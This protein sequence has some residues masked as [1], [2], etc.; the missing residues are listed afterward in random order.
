MKKLSPSLFCSNFHF[1]PPFHSIIARVPPIV[2]ALSSSSSQPKAHSN[3]PAPNSSGS[4][5]LLRFWF[6]FC[7]LCSGSGFALVPTALVR[8][9]SRVFRLVCCSRGCFW[10]LLSEQ[11]RL[12]VSRVEQMRASAHEWAGSL[13]N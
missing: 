7:S 1:V 2:S 5:A 10:F 3:R 9:V 8:V 6:H 12:E 13:L 4:S 11:T